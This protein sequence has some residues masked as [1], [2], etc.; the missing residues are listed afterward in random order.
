MFFFNFEI[1]LLVIEIAILV[2]KDVLDEII[3]P[4]PGLIKPIVELPNADPDPI[5]ISVIYNNIFFLFKFLYFFLYYSLSIL[6][7][8][9]RFS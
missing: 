4:A 1:I 6:R 7:L 3:I 9:Y 5:K 8:F 2:N